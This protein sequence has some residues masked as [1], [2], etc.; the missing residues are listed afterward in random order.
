MKPVAQIRT[1]SNGMARWA[2]INS[3]LPG[4]NGR[5]SSGG[6]GLCSRFRA[7]VRTQ[8]LPLGSCVPRS[9]QIPDKL[10]K[11]RE[12][13]GVIVLAGAQDDRGGH[14]RILEAAVDDVIAAQAL[15]GCRHQADPNIRRNQTQR[16]LQFAHL[17]DTARLQ[18]TLTK[19]GQHL[20]GVA[21]A[22][23]GWVDDQGMRNQVIQAQRAGIVQE[24]MAD[25]QSRYE[26]LLCENLPLDGWIIDM[27]AAEADVDLALFQSA[28]LLHAREFQHVDVEIRVGRMEAADHP[29]QRPVQDRADEA[30]AEPA[31]VDLAHSSGHHLQR[32][33]A[34][35]D[36]EGVLVEEAS[37]VGYPQRAASAL[38]ER[39]AEFLL[40]LLK[41]AAQRGLG[42]VQRLGGSGHAALTDCSHKVAE[43]AQLHAHTS[44]V[45]P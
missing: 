17:A 32:L 38:D 29:G 24:R 31:L 21:R 44:Q 6:L 3:L 23:F 22:R 13:T 45:S 20:V 12:L 1:K 11:G 40:E 19:D 43:M 16:G 4:L 30:D 25:R 33:C 28:Y 36:G 5:L 15:N 9:V 26:R 41:L 14:R 8:V 34:I 27:E 39:H 7:A 18:P 2:I 37:S 42:H 35:Q 10:Q